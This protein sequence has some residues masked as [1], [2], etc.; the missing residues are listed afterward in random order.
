MQ[1]NIDRQ[2][3]LCRDKNTETRPRQTYS[4]AFRD[5]QRQTDRDRHTEKNKQRKTDRQRQTDRARQTET[6]R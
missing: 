1:T 6:A 5:R 4:Q 2:R 3:Q